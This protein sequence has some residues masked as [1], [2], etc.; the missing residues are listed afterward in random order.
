M[1][2]HGGDLTRAPLEYPGVPVAGPRL[3]VGDC[4]HT[5]RPRR[6]RGLGSARSGGCRRCEVPVGSGA[7]SLDR[8]L[9]RLGAAPLAERTPL[10]AV[11]SN[12]A[13][14]VIRHKLTRVG[15]SS[16]VPLLTGVVRNLAI[17]HTAYVSRGGYVPAA[18]VHRSR[19]RT[20][21]VLQLVDDEQLAAIDATEGGYDRV[22]LR[23][24]HYPLVL[25]GGVRPTRFHVYAASEGVLGLPGTGRRFL[26]QHEVLGALHAEGMP[27]TDEVEPAAIAARFAAS[28]DHRL[29]VKGAIADRGMAVDAGLVSH[30]AGVL[31]WPDVVRTP[32]RRR[33]VA[34]GH[35]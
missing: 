2:E 32:R 25:T 5:V 3:V 10:L 14:S 30:P 33:R 7:D 18:P 4:A 13:A 22:E 12:A 29:E 6:S 26:P 9:H 11:G 20:P 8:T 15:V 35:R 21:V 23:A 19:A 27:H 31:R 28:P 34:R 16:V 1:D 24:G 17:G